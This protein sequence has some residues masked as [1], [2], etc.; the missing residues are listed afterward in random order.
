[1]DLISFYSAGESS[2]TSEKQRARSRSAGRPQLGVHYTK[3][4]AEIVERFRL[5]AL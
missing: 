1:M 3:E 2:S 5:S 4:E